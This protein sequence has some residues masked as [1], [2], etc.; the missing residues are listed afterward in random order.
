MTSK[1]ETIMRSAKALLM[2]TTLVWLVLALAMPSLAQTGTGAVNGTITDATGAVVPAATVKLINQA[3]KIEN[4]ATSNDV[5]GFVFINVLPG[6]YQL[7]VSKTGFKTI[8]TDAF[9]VN[10]SKAVTQPIT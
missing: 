3:T 7:E 4:V 5:G 2:F 9:E 8:H 10:V 1:E 6:P